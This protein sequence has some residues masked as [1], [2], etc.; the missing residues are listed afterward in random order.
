MRGWGASRQY[1]ELDG[2]DD[3]YIE[4]QSARFGA[5]GW[6][7]PSETCGSS[8]C[9]GSLFSSL[10]T[11]LPF[12]QI[13][14]SMPSPG[15]SRQNNHGFA[16][17]S[18]WS[19]TRSEKKATNL[20]SLLELLPVLWSRTEMVRSHSWRVEKEDGC[21]LRFTSRWRSERG[22]WKEASI[23]SI[24]EEHNEDWRCYFHHTQQKYT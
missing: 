9:L 5:N 18:G 17:E 2:E 7:W 10:P 24:A 8:A 13:T 22:S 6:S 23:R 3:N 21:P 12:A 11:T 16:P 15:P 19:R 4:T 1:Y 14:F 20:L